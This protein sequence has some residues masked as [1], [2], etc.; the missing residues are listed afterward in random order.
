M[1]ALRTRTLPTCCLLGDTSVVG[2][3]RGVMHVTRRRRVAATL[4]SR[5]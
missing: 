1:G 4:W 2:S 3:E 5:V